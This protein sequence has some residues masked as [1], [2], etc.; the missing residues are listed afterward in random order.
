MGEEEK[1]RRKAV[2]LRYHEKQDA[3]PRVVAKGAGHLAERII[4]LA[5]EH[6]IHVQD[7]PDLVA[8]LSKLDVDMQIPEELYRAVAEVLAFV[9]RLERRMPR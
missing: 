6:G 1:I 3:A 8:V 5:R 9:Y 7:D 2:A 4:A